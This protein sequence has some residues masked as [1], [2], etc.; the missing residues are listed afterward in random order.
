MDSSSQ[1]WS[2]SGK[3]ALVTGGTRGI[4]R[5]IVEELAGLGASVYTCSRSEQNL[6]ERLQEWRQSNLDVHGSTCDLS[7]PSGREELVKLVAQHFGGKLDILVRVF[8]AKKSTFFSCKQRRDQCAEAIHARLHHRGH[9]YSFLHKL[10]VGLSHIAIGSSF[11]QSRWKLQPGFHLLGGRSGGH[12]HG[13]T[14]RSH[15]RCH[16]SNHQELGVRV[17]SRW[18]PRQCSGAVV[19]QNG[20]G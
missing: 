1:R 18:D 9:I 17:G 20:P 6:N 16:E 11:A 19:H 14:L 7:N 10:R 4:G 13:S 2:L 15:Q 12:R 3:S 8:A 5:S